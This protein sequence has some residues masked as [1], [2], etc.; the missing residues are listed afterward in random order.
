VFLRKTSELSN[1][2]QTIPVIIV[3]I[4]VTERTTDATASSIEPAPG[5][6]D[7]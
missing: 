4:F 7:F 5:K 1:L 3:I 6:P 2:F